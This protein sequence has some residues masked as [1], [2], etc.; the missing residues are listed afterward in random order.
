MAATPHFDPPSESA[1]PHCKGI[2]E[3]GIHGGCHG[4]RRV[5]HTTDGKREPYV[6]E[7]KH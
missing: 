2:T 6:N 5:K 3:T 4:C 7:P 1:C